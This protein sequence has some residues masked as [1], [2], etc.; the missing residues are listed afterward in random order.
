MVEDKRIDQLLSFRLFTR[1]A[2]SAFLEDFWT[3]RRIYYIN[4]DYLQALAVS[5]HRSLVIS[6]FLLSFTFNNHS[7]SRALRTTSLEETKHTS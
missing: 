6:Y 7:S 5:L 1:S 3:I 4:E 2:V